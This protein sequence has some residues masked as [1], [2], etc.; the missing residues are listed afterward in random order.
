MM[1]NLNAP[2][3]SPRRPIIRVP[4]HFVKPDVAQTFRMIGIHGLTFT[5]PLVLSCIVFSYEQHTVANAIL[6]G[7]ATLISSFGLHS[8]G[9]MGH[10]GTHFT[11]HP[12]RASSALIGVLTSAFV[13]FH[14]DMGFAIRHNQ[15][16][17]FTNN[18]DKDPD[19]MIFQKFQGFWQR[20]LFARFAATAEY[21]RTALA[22]AFTNYPADW[23][24]GLNLHRDQIVKLARINLI[25]SLA[26][27]VGYGTLII[28]FP[29]AFG[30]AF[31]LTFFFA[32]TLSGL[33]P[34]LE[35]AGTN[36]IKTS[37]SRSWISPAFD[38]LYSG[39]N[40]H[41]AHH[42]APAVPAYR[43]KE[44]HRWLEVQ[45]H[46]SQDNTVTTRS[47][48]EAATVIKDLPYGRH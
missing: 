6:V 44:F 48:R 19:I 46:I 13:P 23:D 26:I 5:L 39:I 16:H 21:F 18:K 37:N 29:G 27:T 15:H 8:L 7:L 1:G 47:F 17:R 14:I 42:I 35:H 41:L 12:K 22:V 25:A 45:G 10:E 33:R 31:G 43:I 24:N 2:S 40:Y 9:L 4:A 20:F 28:F 30:I 11:L 32:I 36:D 38:V 34:Y 3:Q